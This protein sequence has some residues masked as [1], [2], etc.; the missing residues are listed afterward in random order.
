LGLVLFYFVEVFV[1]LLTSLK[2]YSVDSSFCLE[3][4]Y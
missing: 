3:I 4:N 2:S 1:V